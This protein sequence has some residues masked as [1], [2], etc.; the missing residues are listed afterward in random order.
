[1]RTKP[2]FADLH[3]ICRNQFLQ[4]NDRLQL[5]AQKGDMIEFRPFEIYR[6]PD[7]QDAAV[8]RGVSKA[9]AWTSAHQ[10]GLAVDFVPYVDGKFDWHVDLPHWVQLH[11]EAR[12]FGLLAPIA[13]DKPH[14]EHPVFEII[15]QVWRKKR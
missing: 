1:M 7:E 8:A 11:E 12:R 10:Y 5:L 2:D 6:S 9:K 4:L 3:M 14:I 15:R 13:W